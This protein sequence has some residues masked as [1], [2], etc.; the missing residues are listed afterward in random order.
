MQPGTT[1]LR[2]NDAEAYLFTNGN[3]AFFD[4]D[5]EQIPDLQKHGWRG[6]HGFHEQYPE[7]SVYFA[8][9]DGPHIYRFDAKDVAVILEHLRRPQEGD[10]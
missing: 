10:E 8:E 7:S 6:L 4:G 1:H 3:A 2:N 9:F 5:G